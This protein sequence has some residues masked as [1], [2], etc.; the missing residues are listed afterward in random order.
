MHLPRRE[1]EQGES[2]SFPRLHPAPGMSQTFPP[3][4]L[5]FP[6]L[7][8]LHPACL[9]APSRLSRLQLPA[10]FARAAL[11]AAEPRAWPEPRPA[12]AELYP[13]RLSFTHPGWAEFAA[14][15]TPS[16]G[17]YP[18]RSPRKCPCFQ[19]RT[20]RSCRAR[21]TR[22]PCGSSRCSRPQDFWAGRICILAQ[23]WEEPCPG[24]ALL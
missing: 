18:S 4:S 17:V 19:R 13:P 10:P 15:P 14:P 1:E 24:L 6:K 22:R 3:G 7:L 9:P 5:A 23:R 8:R 21:T 20:S 11:G 16:S 12:Q 2:S